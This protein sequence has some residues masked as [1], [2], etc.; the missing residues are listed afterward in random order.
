MTV[1]QQQGKP[2]TAVAKQER[3]EMLAELAQKYT[4]EI[5][6]L[7][8]EGMTAAM[9]IASLRLYLSTNPAVAECTKLSIA[10]GVLRAAQTGLTLGVSCDLL[11]F[12]KVAQFSPRYGGIIELALAAG[13]NAINAD[14][15]RAGDLFEFEKGTK[16]YLRHTRGFKRDG[17]I[18]HAYAVAAL[19]FGQCVF[20]VATREE[21]DRV[22]EQ[23]SR[24][25]KRDVDAFGHQRREPLELDLIP[26]YAKKTMVRKLA[27][28]LPKNPRLAAALLFAEAKGPEEGDTAGIQTPEPEH[29]PDGEIL[30]TVE[31]I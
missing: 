23:F 27:P 14:V 18:T 17:L 26:W 22:R 10:Q 30:G 13:V 24:S 31:E 11:P 29:T 21:V 1:P 2:G 6:A 20:E 12:N 7:A 3:E 8:P 28:F 15:V 25:W 9:F 19:R 5:E 4:P 16:P